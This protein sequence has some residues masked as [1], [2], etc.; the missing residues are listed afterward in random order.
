[1]TI[2]EV[3]DTEL[4]YTKIGSG[5]PFLVMHG[6]LGMD[7]TYF[8]PE[9]D[10]LDDSMQLIYFDYRGH[11]RSARSPINTITFEQLAND[12]EEL[13]KVLGYDKIG[14]I[15]HSI[16]GFVALTYAIKYPQN[17]SYL[18]PMNIYPA[19]DRTHVKEFLAGVQAKNPSREV[20][21]VF[22]GPPASSVEEFKD[23]YKI[24]NYLYVYDYNSKIKKRLEEKFEDMILNIELAAVTNKLTAKF[25]VISDLNKITAPSL[26]IGGLGDGIIPVSQVQ[27]LHDNLPNSELRFFEKSGHY[28]FLE[29]PKTFIKVVLEWFS[30]V[31]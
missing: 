18:I 15:G 20:M 28:P 25:N 16:G 5:T 22:N 17:L 23:N 7:H 14:V 19:F 3:N 31:K 27:R 21:N 13:R 11:G 26:V 2:I 1:M 10:P 29:E 12:A 30:K 4:F 6:G 8:R 24:L 9:L